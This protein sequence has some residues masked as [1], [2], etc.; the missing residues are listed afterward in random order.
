[1]NFLDPDVYVARQLELTAAL[2]ESGLSASIEIAAAELVAQARDAK[3]AGCEIPPFWLCDRL[4]LSP[5]EERVVWLLVAHELSP[6][7]RQ[8]LRAL[9]TE[10]VVDVT[11]DTIRRL[12]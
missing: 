4:G 10:T 1:M 5:R 9:A 6:R 11:H 2:V 8:R 7:V 3:H 12:V